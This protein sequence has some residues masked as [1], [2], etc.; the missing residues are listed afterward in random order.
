MKSYFLFL[1]IFLFS[2]S[3]AQT[4]E[5]RVSLDSGLFS[6]GGEGAFSSSSMVIYPGRTDG[7]TLNP[8]GSD[9]AF[10][11]GLSVDWRHITSSKTLFGFSLGYEIVRSKTTITLVQGDFSS[12]YGNINGFLPSGAETVTTNYDLNAFPYAGHRF[13]I[14]K[15]PVDLVFGV[16]VAYILGSTEKGEANGTSVISGTV[17]TVGG[18]GN[19]GTVPVL[20]AII[21][22][23]QT[24]YTSSNNIYNTSFDLRPRLQVSADYYNFGLYLGYSYGLVNYNTNPRSGANTGNTYSRM[25][26]F[27]VT[28]K[29]F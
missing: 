8:Y 24:T 2:I 6:Y 3:N 7:Y 25:I 28:Y 15:T 19:G 27:G 1:A 29:L 16:D 26:R 10:C 12:F 21:P 22:T 14:K 17:V 18:G 4:T 23:N 5:Y 13:M 20:G 11:Y 9:V